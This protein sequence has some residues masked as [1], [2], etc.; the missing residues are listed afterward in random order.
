MNDQAHVVC[1][2]RHALL[3]LIE[4]NIDGLDLGSPQLEAQVGRG[5]L[6]RHRDYGLLNLRWIKRTAADEA[7]P[8]PQS[9]HSRLW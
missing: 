5:Q 2:V 4:R 6:A 3:N 8:V 7:R 9:A 1:A